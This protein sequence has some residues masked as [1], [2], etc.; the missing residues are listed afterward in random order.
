[1]ALTAVVHALALASFYP[2]YER[3]TCLEIKGVST[4]LDGHAPG[5]DD[6]R[7]GRRIGE[8]HAAWA[9]RLP[10]A[11][12][13]LWPFL[14]GLGAG[15]LLELLAHCASLTVNAVRS[16][17]DRK[18]GAW[19]HADRLA[20]ALNLDMAAYWTATVASYFGR[21]TKARIAEAVGEAVS[22]EAAERI[23]GLK[24]PDMAAEAEALLAGKGWL[25]PLLRTANSVRPGEAIQEEPGSPEQVAA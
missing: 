7:A 1:V 3:P 14:Q 16:P 12:E 25:P 9:T 23:A 15:D 21:V 24:K 18:P 2:A 6:T 5:I 11:V 10:K 13:E 8:R 4:Y 20:E 17:F 22:E 19:A